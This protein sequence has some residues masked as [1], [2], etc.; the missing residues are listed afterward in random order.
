M[1]QRPSRPTSRKTLLGAAA[2]VAL[3]ALNAPAVAGFAQ[4]AYHRY[5]I[6]QPE[7]K[8]RPRTPHDSLALCKT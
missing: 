3:A 2:V 8:A 4:H 7:Y 6:N 5:E 1:A